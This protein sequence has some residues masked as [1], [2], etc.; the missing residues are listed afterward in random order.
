ML[1]ETLT[2]FKIAQQ[3]VAE[4]IQT[5]NEE[6]PHISLNYQTPDE[7]YYANNSQQIDELSIR[8]A[9]SDKLNLSYGSNVDNSEVIN[10]ESASYPHKSEGF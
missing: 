5:Y 8:A 4:A 9:E 1:G 10:T 2:S 6:R 3:L 7:V